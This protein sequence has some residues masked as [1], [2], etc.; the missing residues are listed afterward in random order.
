MTH[1]PTPPARGGGS[2]CWNC[3]QPL[4]AGSVRCLWCGVSQLAAAAP[5]VV[6][7]GSLVPAGMSVLAS[8]PAQQNGQLAQPAVALQ[9][10]PV[11]RRE[12]SRRAA[13]LGRVALGPA[14]SGSAASTAARVGAFT[15]DVIAVLGG[16]TIV[17]VLA[18]SVLFGG[19]ALV[20]LAVGL[21]VLEARTG[22]TVGNALLR[23]RA[24]RD[25]APYSPGFGRS[26]VRWLITGAGFLVFVVGAWIVVASSAW[27]SARLGRTWADRAARTLVV[28]VPRRTAVA[29][30]TAPVVPS[31]PLSAPAA[32]PISPP[33]SQPIAAVVLA[34]PQV[35]STATRTTEIDEDSASASRT[36]VAASG[37][38]ASPVPVLDQANAP[39]TI[40]P[41]SGVNADGAED[42]LMLIF[43]TGQ[44]EQ[45][46]TPVI[47]N[48]GR[49]PAP[50]EPGDKLI[51]VNDPES[52]V[53]KTHL[54]LEHSRGRTWV[55]DGGS[56][57][58]TDMISDD[59]D[60]T[61]LTAGDR[62]LVEEGDRVRIG[63]RAFT[64]SRLLGGEKA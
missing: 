48:L 49:N 11:S 1:L 17:T 15:L 39:T 22:L 42:T 6:A 4:Q 25:D 27:D 45:F 19:L 35:I 16:A 24:A 62:V 5:L 47:I 34:A 61:R 23:L 8:A 29:S 38:A 63:N 60:V 37:F 40:T 52:T 10:V 33:I 43:D 56:T 59:G 41:P 55:T 50:T 51:I 30:T 36:G 44:R 12:A 9:P 54:R 3:Q 21:L 58:G 13:T 64:I 46:G 53:S 2:A 32:Y 14:F 57:N 20:E 18:K 26:F 28:A 7:P 31:A